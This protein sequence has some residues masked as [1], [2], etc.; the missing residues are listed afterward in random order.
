MGWTLKDCPC[1]VSG[2]SGVNR[3]P[4]FF[5]E[6]FHNW[7][8]IV[9]SVEMGWRLPLPIYPNV[10]LILLSMLPQNYHQEVNKFKN[11]YVLVFCNAGGIRVQWKWFKPDG[12]HISK[13]KQIPIDYL[14]DKRR[15]L[16]TEEYN[17]IPFLGIYF[18][19]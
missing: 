11:L 15:D 12:V 10:L 16:R 7:L 14:P 9:L 3:G 6:K 2:Y 5:C 8:P 1:P 4:N 18:T 17:N 19:P 13:G